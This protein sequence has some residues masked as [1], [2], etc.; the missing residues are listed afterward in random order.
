MSGNN[1]QKLELWKKFVAQNESSRNNIVKTIPLETQNKFAPIFD[2]QE[3]KQNLVTAEDFKNISLN[4]LKLLDPNSSKKLNALSAESNASSASNAP[5][6]APSAKSNAPPVAPSAES[7]A[8]PNAQ[9]TKKE[10]QAAT[11][12]G[13]LSPLTPEQIAEKIA[14][15]IELKKDTHHIRYVVKNTD[16]CYN[17]TIKPEGEVTTESIETLIKNNTNLCIVAIDIA[18]HNSYE[19]LYSPENATQVNTNEAAQ[20]AKKDVEGAT[21]KKEGGRHRRSTKKHRRNKKKNA[22]RHK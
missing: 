11:S 8:P 19:I 14:A 12:T 10:A 21:P 5:P 17:P 3:N 7:N 6:V 9:L 13:N 1:A 4:E 15:S 18:N 16:N 22:T 2:K 20:R